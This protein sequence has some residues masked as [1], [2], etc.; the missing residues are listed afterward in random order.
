LCVVNLGDPMPL[1]D[2][3]EILLTSVAL[4]GDRLPTDAAAWLRA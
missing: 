1:P 2:H 3:S 4:D